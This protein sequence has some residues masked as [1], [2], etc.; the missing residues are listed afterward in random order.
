M[1]WV[2]HSFIHSCCKQSSGVQV[3]C[4]LSGAGTVGTQL[5]G[6]LLVQDAGGWG[7]RSCRQ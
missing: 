2:I 7:D 3:L 5:L 4:W 6:E 1:D